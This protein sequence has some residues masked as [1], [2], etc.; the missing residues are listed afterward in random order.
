MYHSSVIHVIKFF[1]YEHLPQKLQD[2]SR[3]FHELARKV[4]DWAPDNPETTVALR[5]LLE[6]KD[7]AIRAAR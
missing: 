7:A 3:P 1:N 4:A 2:I 6:A 5:K